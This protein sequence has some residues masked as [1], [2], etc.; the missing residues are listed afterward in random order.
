MAGI[1]NF[2]IIAAL[3]AVVAALFLGLLSMAKGGDFNARYGNKLMRL[4]VIIQGAAVALIGLS[5]LLLA[6][7]H[8]G[9]G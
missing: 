2:A 3:V 4:R 7:N 8:Y 1:L 5:M 6:W 9:N